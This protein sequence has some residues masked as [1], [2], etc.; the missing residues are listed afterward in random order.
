MIFLLHSLR[1][2]HN[3]GVPLSR[4]VG[5][6]VP[7]ALVLTRKQASAESAIKILFFGGLPKNLGEG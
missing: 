7:K 3:I 6:A 1:V 4:L 5:V 2:P